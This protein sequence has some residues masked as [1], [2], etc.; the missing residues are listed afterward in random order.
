MFVL[1]LPL[2]APA[3]GNE[4][5]WDAYMAQ[6]EKGPGSTLINL[7]AKDTAPV[8]NLPFLLTTG[9]TFKNCTTE[10]LPSSTE[11]PKLYRV[12]DSV[13]TVVDTKINNMLVG[14]F[15]YQCQRFDYYYLQDTSGVSGRPCLICI[16][17][18][19]GLC[20]LYKY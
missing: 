14:T 11:L 20:P 16:K 17:N 19:S 6:Y 10:G 12:S 18:I 4:G 5:D 13:K 7:S 8:K 1:L 15:T 2:F 3:Q 9:V